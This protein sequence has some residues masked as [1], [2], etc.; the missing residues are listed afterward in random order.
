[1]RCRRRDI[2]PAL[3]LA[4]LS[5]CGPSTK[6]VREA[7]LPVGEVL[8]RVRERNEKVRTLKGDGT[9]TIESPE[10]STSGFFT[11]RLKKPDSLL[12]EFKGPFGIHVGT[13]MLSRGQFTFFNKM[14]N[15]AIVGAPDG[16]TLQSMF[17]LKMEFDEV[18]NVFTGEFPGAGAGDS[19]MAFSTY[20]GRYDISYTSG[21]TVKEYNV[22]G[23]AFVVRGYKVVDTSGTPTLTAVADRVDDSPPAPVPKFL[24][25]IFPREHRSITI[26]YSGIE[27]NRPVDCSLSLPERVEII[28]R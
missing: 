2:I 9:I 26:A 22:D 28:N 5:G 10:G 17:R 14:E 6:S 16:R 3:L 11:A 19:L 23:E 15:R 4:V 13:L 7:P 1:M 21:E 25:V 20:D 8:R 27:L 24:R 12:V 18:L